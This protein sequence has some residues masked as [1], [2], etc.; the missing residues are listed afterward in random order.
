MSQP[1]PAAEFRR[2]VEA[3]RADQ[4][5]SRESDLG[6]RPPRVSKEGQL[7][8]FLLSHATE[9]LALVEDGDA[10]PKH[11]AWDAAVS[12]YANQEPNND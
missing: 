1:I 6:V 3:W 12:P 2:L 8:D 10:V 9:L 5:V 7:S 4:K 11:T